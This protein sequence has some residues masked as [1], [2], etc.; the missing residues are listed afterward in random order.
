MLNFITR[1]FTCMFYVI[2]SKDWK[3]PLTFDIFYFKTHFIIL[4]LLTIFKNTAL[5]SLFWKWLNKPFRIFGFV[6]NFFLEIVAVLKFLSYFDKKI[7]N[8]KLSYG[9]WNH[10]N[11]NLNPVDVNLASQTSKRK[12][13]SP[14][15]VLYEKVFLEVLQNSQENTCARVSF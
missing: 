1:S 5:F 11:K 14:G 7:R 6:R 9:K 15:G 4:L 10:W 12:K 13:Q 8:H 3:K 2:F